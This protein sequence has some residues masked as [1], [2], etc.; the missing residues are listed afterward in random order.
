MNCVKSD[1]TS[2]LGAY[3]YCSKI[4]WYPNDHF[5]GENLTR[6]NFR[7][8][9]VLA[10]CHLRGLFLLAFIMLST[11]G[12]SG[13]SFVYGLAE[14]AVARE[15]EFHLD[16]DENGG[17]L[18]D[19]KVDALLGW[20]SKDMLP[21]YARFMNAQADVI[22]HAALSQDEVDRAV[23]EL[24][25][26]LEALVAGA[27]R[28]SADVLVE[29]TE[30]EKVR[31]IEARMA[32]RLA[33]RW[34]DQEEAP[35]ERLEARIEGITDNF[36]R[37]T[38]PLSDAQKEAIQT[39]AKATLRDTEVWLRNRE[40]RQRAFTEFL[41]QEPDRKQIEAFV[42][43]IILRPHEIV[44][45]QYRAISEARWKRFQSLLY[46]IMTTLSPEQR[47]MTSETLRRYA[48]EMLE[49]AS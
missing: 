36:E 8:I 20:H 45:H 14:I 6:N 30:P 25:K 32:E 24:R 10:V 2:I 37:F 42:Y 29:H 15:A 18:V 5:I 7:A 43:K 26:L 44:D 35:E 4:D 13:V 3:Q 34:E 38:G 47:Q 33:E 31:Y 21:R 19:E 11:A 17:A 48:A 28:Y 39:Y 1:L 41:A 22:D 12:C 40:N 49:L 46:G 23:V 9:A 27:S 16:L